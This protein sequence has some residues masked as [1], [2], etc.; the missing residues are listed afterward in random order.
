MNK[1]KILHKFLSENANKVNA[2]LKKFLPKDNSLI[3]QA[4]RYSV[5]A[6]GKRI[7]PAL[8]ILAAK[9]FGAN[10]A[11]VMPAACALEYLH[12]YSLVHDDLP[13]MDND[14]LRRGKPTSH[15]KFG[16]AQAL[17][18][19]DALLTESFAL[20]VKSKANPKNINKAVSILADLSGYK[21]MI[22]G[23]AQ[24]TFEQ[25][26]WQKKSKVLLAKKLKFIQRKK[27]SALLAASLTIG[28]ALAGAKEKDLK[29]LENYANNIGCAFQIIDDILDVFADK[30]LLGKKGSDAANNKLTSLSLY[31]RQKAVQMALS[32]IKA[33][34]NAVSVYGKKAR[35]LSM[36]ADYIVERKY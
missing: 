22:A 25:G 16:E 29:I 23:Q 17:L 27:T 35:M 1:E 3:C 18:C 30:K 26:K 4:M 14:D 21:G 15:K 11:S 34:K 19:G 24:D 36:L 9:I 20:L 10:A 8:V 2:A 31:G 33:A 13:S 32:H 5:L 7:R 6:G 28:A 12:T